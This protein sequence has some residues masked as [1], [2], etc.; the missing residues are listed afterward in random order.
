MKSDTWKKDLDTFLRKLVSER[1]VYFPIRHHSPACAWHARRLIASIKPASILIEGPETYNEFIKDICDESTVAPIAIFS[2]FTDRK[3]RTR[4]SKEAESAPVPT[5]PIR[6]NS[7]F[8]LCDYS[9][10]L[11]AMRE[12]TKIGARISF[13]DLDYALQ[14][15]IEKDSKGKSKRAKSLQD[16]SRLSR[17]R[18]LNEL[19]KRKGCRDFN[20][21]W[22]RLFEVAYSDLDTD[23]FIR[24]IAGYCFLSRLH[25][26]E[27]DLANDGTLAREL[28]MRQIIDRE[29]KRLGRQ[30][31]QKP[32]L[33]ITGGF[34]T[35]ALFDS[36]STKARI[37]ETTFDE[38][39]RIHSLIPYSFKQLDSLNGYAA[40]MPSPYY[41]QRLWEESDRPFEQASEIVCLETLSSAA[42]ETRDSKS[43]R[44]LSTA[45]TI[46]A[47]A[48]AKT[49]AR[50]RGAAGPC[51][52]D[53]L[54]G[55][56]SCFVKGQEDAEGVETLGLVG[57]IMRGDLVGRLTSRAKLHGIVLDFRSTAASLG[58]SLETTE[59][60]ETALNIYKKPL[61]R[62]KSRFLARVEFLGAPFARML[63]GPDF[64]AGN[65]LDSKIERWEYSWSPQ[66]DSSLIEAAIY[67]SSIEEA[68]VGKLVART[69]E[70]NDEGA[71]VGASRSVA[72]LLLCCRLGLHD[73][74]NEFLPDISNKLQNEN[75]LT[76]AVNAT[77]SLDLLSKY[78]GP[79]ETQRLKGSESLIQQGYNRCIYLLERIEEHKEEVQSQALDSLSEMRS[80][81]GKDSER[82]LDESLFYATLER[83]SYQSSLEPSVRGGIMGLLYSTGRRSIET[84]LA[85][86]EASLIGADAKGG[87]GARF[88][89]GLF[90]LN[91]DLTWTE[92]E[93]M[94]R[95]NELLTSWSSSDFYQAL[96]HLRLAFAQ[97]TPQE[98]DKVAKLVSSLSGH[99]SGL[100]DW[101]QRS[102]PED[103]VNENLRVAERVAKSIERDKLQELYR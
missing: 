33:V 4:Q 1:V 91:R 37:P 80:L 97:H 98:T 35:P 75:D 9:P 25:E 65:Q 45:D 41:Y 71:E 19:A 92:S 29:L 27:E 20:D 32:L 93:V 24:N 49:L 72:L 100:S 51:R 2:Q 46:A 8:P 58:F 10:E 99:E 70:M 74:A 82:R 54:D 101:Y 77:A 13:C 11:V 69:Q 42:R 12:G 78:S 21:L 5:Q 40:G 94:R 63:A 102:F 73:F 22:D 53:L 59:R 23:E 47:L 61:H 89:A 50:F 16:E 67:G 57:R 88:L 31:I 48:Q 86:I 39:E 95:L 84:L 64:I 38:G 43:A 56:R 3:R 7:Y 68:V 14:F 96:P 44:P 15:L 6:Y 83:L 66:V 90:C 103:F 76:E 55:V 34:H 28:R 26:S 60:R 85:A 87:V 17:S 62:R 81:L 18:Y 30:K 79:L 36:K 52:E